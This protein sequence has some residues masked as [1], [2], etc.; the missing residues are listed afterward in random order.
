MTDGKQ[1]YC[2][3]HFK[4]YRNIVSLYCTPGTNIVLQVNYSSNKQIS[5]QKKR[6]DLWLPEVGV[7]EGEM[8]KVD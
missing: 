8:V 7:E 3:D 2:G 1:T 5:S 4:M 6:S